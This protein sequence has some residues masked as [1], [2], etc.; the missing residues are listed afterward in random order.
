[1]KTKHQTIAIDAIL[2]EDRLRPTDP[3]WVDALAAS[4]DQ[5]GLQQPI[6]VVT[7]GKG[8]ELLA[9]G[10]R[11]AAA[12]QLGWSEID[13]L[14]H[15]AKSLKD[16]ERV[17]I[18]ITENVVRNELSAL[19]RALKLK[20]LK[21]IYLELNPH[22]TRGGDRR[23]EAEL[24]ESSEQTATIAVWL[25]ASF[26]KVAAEQIG[27]S[28]R[29]IE[30]AVGMANGLTEDSVDRLRLTTH[31]RHQ[32]GL[33]ALSKLNADQQRVVC[34]LLADDT[35][36]VASLPEAIAAISGRPAPNAGERFIQ[37]FTNNFGRLKPRE[38]AAIFSAIEAEFLKWHA[39]KGG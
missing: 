14:V 16:H 34:D 11:L 23:R 9:G 19:D 15:Q 10:H 38:K 25:G 20:V 28:E 7:K 31:A 35:S 30:T 39:R 8:F 36:D 37:S 5:Q 18:E 32:A 22:A 4:I 27:L 2:A 6:V 33:I 3:A 26:G 29:L 21:A 13:A 1:M 12:K 24:A 17:L